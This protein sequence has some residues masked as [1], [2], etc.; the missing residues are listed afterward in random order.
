[1]KS[2]RS[3][4]CTGGEADW[5]AASDRAPCVLGSPTDRGLAACRGRSHHAKVVERG[6]ATIEKSVE[7]ARGH[8][9]PRRTPGHGSRGALPAPVSGD[10][11][12][13]LEEGGWLKGAVR[14]C[15]LAVANLRKAAKDIPVC[16]CLTLERPV[17]GVTQI[18]RHNGNR[19]TRKHESGAP[20]RIPSSS[21]SS[22]NRSSWQRQRSSV[23][24]WSMFSPHDRLRAM[25]EEPIQ[26]RGC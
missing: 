10:S 26:T 13:L 19:S 4:A 6:A 1:V 22:S 15:A 20:A 3:D 18:E 12:A 9:Y 17:G 23:I 25:V 7:V 24:V 11:V 8:S 2:S 5:V 16:N 21:M 14:A